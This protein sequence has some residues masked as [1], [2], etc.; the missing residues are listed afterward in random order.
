MLGDRRV[1]ST[2]IVRV[3]AGHY[4]F[5]TLGSLAWPI[6]QALVNIPIPNNGSSFSIPT[7]NQFV[8]STGNFTKAS[9]ISP[10]LLLSQSLFRDVDHESSEYLTMGKSRSPSS[11]V[12]T[13]LANDQNWAT[14]MRLKMPIHK[15]KMMPSGTL[16]RE[17]R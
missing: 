10:Q 2:L 17:R 6:S 8:Y 3:H 15:K 11:F 16:N 4:S 12:Y 14:I 5:H 1:D 9:L 7:V 13:S